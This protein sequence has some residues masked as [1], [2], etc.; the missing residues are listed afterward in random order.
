MPLEISDT[1]EGLD[2]SWPLSGDPTDEGDNHIR[3]VK[4][5]LKAQFPGSAGDGYSE[6]I[7]AL[8]DDLNNCTGSTGNFQEQIDALEERLDTTLPA[9]AGT[10]LVFYQ[11]T[12]PAGW[13]QDTTKNNFMVRTVSGS[14]GGS[15]G[16]D[17]PIFNNKVPSHYHNLTGTAQTAGGHSHTMQG[18]WESWGYPQTWGVHGLT[19]G[20]LSTNAAGDH[21]HSVTGTTQTPIGTGGGVVGNW[22][23]QYIDVIIAVKDAP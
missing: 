22:E 7:L 5:V 20:T 11:A 19:E 12:P 1:I 17:S 18:S 16:S 4:H 15:G 10:E 6:A 21:T 23:P 2:S 14:G 8:E 3:L 13:T 9:P